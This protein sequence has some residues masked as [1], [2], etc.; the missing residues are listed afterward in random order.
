M[1]G[2]GVSP[3]K[4]GSR[5]TNNLGGTE[6]RNE[7]QWSAVAQEDLDQASQVLSLAHPLSAG[8]VAVNLSILGI[9]DFSRLPR[10]T[11]LTFEK[12]VVL[13]V[14]EYNPPCSRMARYISEGHETTHGGVLAE[15]D[16]I[17][18][19]KFSRGLVGVVEVPG[20]VSVGEGVSVTP[21][22]LPKWLRT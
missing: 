2:T 1:T 11:T 16:F 12:G 5:L 14:E 3:A 17:E 9:P 7:R 10:G 20:V 18:A 4:P 15:T 22:V 13:M 19:S 21:E 8:D 6:R